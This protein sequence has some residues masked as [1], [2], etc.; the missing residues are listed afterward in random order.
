MA[1]RTYQKKCPEIN[2]Y[3]VNSAPYS[4]LWKADQDAPVHIKRSALH[5][6]AFLLI[7]EAGIAKPTNQ[8]F[9]SPKGMFRAW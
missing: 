8:P 2:I 5:V 9:D 4:L 6:T 1:K 7:S 3:E